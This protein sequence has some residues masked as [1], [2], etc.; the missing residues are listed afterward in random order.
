MVE[1]NRTDLVADMNRASLKASL[2]WTFLNNGYDCQE[3][4]K[5]AEMAIG[6]VAKSLELAHA[7]YKLHI[8]AIESSVAKTVVSV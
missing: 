6:P 8:E 2:H 7:A 5:L 3:A 4:T 1:L